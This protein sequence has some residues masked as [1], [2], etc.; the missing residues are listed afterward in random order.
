MR[1]QVTVQVDEEE[2]VTGAVTAVWPAH[3]ERDVVNGELQVVVHHEPQLK[4]NSTYYPLRD[5]IY[6]KADRTLVFTEAAVFGALALLILLSSWRKVEYAV[7]KNTTGVD[8]IA[9]ARAG[10][11]TSRFDLFVEELFRRIAQAKDDRVD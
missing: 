6:A 9:I 5:V 2:P 11:D 8:A 1:R 3:D 4:I 10:P 7:F